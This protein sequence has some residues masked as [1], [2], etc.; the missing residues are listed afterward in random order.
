M[1][2]KERFKGLKGKVNLIR[3]NDDN[4]KYE[5]VPMNVVNMKEGTSN[6]DMLD[7]L[8]AIGDL[9]EDIVE[10]FK[11][12]DITTIEGDIWWYIFL[13]VHIELM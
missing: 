13:V 6:D 8:K 12:I 7:V 1:T 3:Y 5:D 2:V 4:G 9:S 11:R 10:S